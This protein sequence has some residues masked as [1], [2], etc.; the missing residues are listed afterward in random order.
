MLKEEAKIDSR[1]L[2]GV[3]LAIAV[4]VAII[5]VT[6][7]DTTGKKG[8]GLSSV[9]DY[10]PLKL[11]GFDP[12]LIIY[13]ESAPE[14]A[15]GMTEARCIIIDAGDQIYVTGDKQI[16]VYDNN[17]NL[18]QTIELS[19]GPVSLCVYEDKMYVAFVDHV[20]VMDLKGRQIARWESPGPRTIL[21][22]IDVY[23]DNVFVADPG[24]RIITRYDTEGNEIN[25]IG[26]PDRENDY[27]GLIVPSAHLDLEVAP[28]G[29]LRV[30]NPG[31]NRIEAFTFAG[32]MEWGFGQRSVRI[33]GFCGCCNP[34][35]FTML[36]DSSYVTCEKGLV[37]I[38]IYNSLGDLQGVVADSKILLKGKEPRVC[39]T[40]EECQSGGF[41]IAVDSRQRVFVL[42]TINNVIRVFSPVEEK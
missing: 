35:S 26:E 4:A 17:L 27:L 12:N 19:A 41:D 31:Q 21:T 15:I 39:E 5:S 20:E 40:V 30:T 24:N 32:S 18:R 13:E 36:S 29:L 42:D 6:T 28:D 9:Y 22:A 7:L 38:K 23:N 8:S 1:F 10:D 11:A 34:V 14:V 16:L 33:E 2:I 3:L 25:K 37:R